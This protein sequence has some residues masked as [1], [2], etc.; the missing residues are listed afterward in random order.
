MSSE[1]S[2]D[3]CFIGSQLS[4]SCHSFVY[5]RKAGIKQVSSLD[6][7]QI[8][9]ISLRT[10]LDNIKDKTICFHHEQTTLF[11]YSHLQK[12]CCDPFLKHKKAVKAGLREVSLEASADFQ[13]LGISVIPGHK[14]CPTC[15]A[16]L[17]RRLQ[18]FD[19]EPEEMEMQEACKVMQN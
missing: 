2:L 9:L 18:D 3:N 11:K 19:E 1:E 8:K 4:Q 16:E 7:S 13:S 12:K 6:A 17:S 5:S 15:H 10:G 14:M